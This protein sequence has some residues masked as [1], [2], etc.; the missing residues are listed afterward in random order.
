[1]EDLPVKYFPDGPSNIVEPSVYESD[2][3]LIITD[4]GPDKELPSEMDYPSVW[5]LFSQPVV[6]LSMLGTPSDTSQILE[7]DPPLKGVFRWY[8]TKLLSFDSS[9]KGLPQHIY[10]I[11]INDQ[12]MSLGG[13]LLTGRS[14]FSFHTEYLSL[15]SVI[16]FL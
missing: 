9:E 7:I 11:S 15:V 12:L 16:V 10:N 1:M 2:E 8:G 3:P 13:K 5:V 6:P 14:G 4:F